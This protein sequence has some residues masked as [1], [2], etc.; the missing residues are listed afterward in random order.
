MKK[1]IALVITASSLLPVSAV[2]P[3]KSQT[4]TSPDQVPEGLSA[5]DWSSIRRIRTASST[6]QAPSV[7]S[8]QA[9]LKA[10]NTGAEDYFGYS[11]AVS[12]DTVVVGAYLE[13]SSTTGVN[14]TPNENASFAGAAY[15]FVRINGVWSQQAYLKASTS[16]AGKFFGYSVAISSDT[17]VVGAPFDD[18][19]PNNSFADPEGAA[20]IF[21]RS[22]GVW[23]QQAYLQ[24]SN[25]GVSDEFGS[26]V[27]I[28]GDTVVVGAIREDSS[29][30]G[31]NSTPND[32]ATDSGAAY[33]F[34]R[35]GSSWSQQ[36]YLKASNTGAEDFFG[37]S[38]SISGD[39]V[40]VGA[41]N[42]DSS[43]TGVNSTPNDAAADSGA[44]Y[45]FTRSGS[46]WSQQAYLKA[47]NSGAEDFFGNS[48]AVSGN[49]VVV[50]AS[51]EASSTSGVN[52]TPDDNGFSI[53]AAYV[54]TRSGINWSQQAYL[55][56]SNNTGRPDSFGSSVAI[57]GDAVVFG[58]FNRARGVG[59][60]YV[61]T[62]SGGSWSEQ[63]Y[64]QASNAGADDRFGFSAA[65]SDGTFVVGAQLEDSSTTGVNSTPNDAAADSG[66]AYIF[67]LP[68]AEQLPVLGIAFSKSS[69]PSGQDQVTLSTIA[70]GVPNRNFE[71]YVSDNLF[72]W[73]FLQNV[74][75]SSSGTLNL[76]LNQAPG[77]PKRFF[78]LCPASSL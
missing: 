34:T 18:S 55:K 78:R 47:G 15:V 50:G 26:S 10:S 32:G 43:T 66:A 67:T 46:S 56:A 21:T 58:A 68:V 41:Y 63:A 70:S 7:I 14:S 57:S 23:S 75:L 65:I 28:S 6:A 4:L 8:Q 54:F 11:V 53:G 12:G 52:S 20:Y 51:G 38:L 74:T 44:A 5:S 40:V 29:T 71:L 64:L 39:T 17:I 3:G 76:T 25:F 61:F 48:V 24:A 62:R 73:T 59:A 60:A 13:D 9:Y 33:V 19:T 49:T 30:T 45:V 22:N 77:I 2:E 35:S 16:V 42:E 1:L 36:A 69:G 72:N 37:G 31:V 27:A